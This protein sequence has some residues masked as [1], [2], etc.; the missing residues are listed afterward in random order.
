VIV[1]LNLA[2]NPFR[3]R[4][5][6]YLLAFV[7]F[8]IGATATAY[9]IFSWRQYKAEEEIIRNQ[10]EQMES[11]IASL[12]QQGAEVRQQLT[13]QQQQILVAAHQLVANKSFS[14][15][16]LFADLERVLPPSVS[17]SRISVQNVFVEGE[18]EKAELE[19]TVISRDFGSVMSM[20]SAMNNSGVFSAE[21][22]G[23]DLQRTDHSSYMEYRLRVIYSPAYGYSASD[24]AEN[25]REANSQ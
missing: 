17:A 15:S 18:R 10:T 1:E 5:I 13:P 7:L 19:L 8:L 21:L 6:P 2:T 25:P 4:A 24:V 14:W 3:N 16:R 23:Q 20:I 12:R 22:R 9:S 11:E